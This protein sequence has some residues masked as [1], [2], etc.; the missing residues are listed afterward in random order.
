MDSKRKDKRQQAEQWKRHCQRCAE[1]RTTLVRRKAH[2]KKDALKTGLEPHPGENYREHMQM[3]HYTVHLQLSAFFYGGGLSQPISVDTAI[4]AGRKVALRKFCVENDLWDGDHSVFRAFFRELVNRIM[5][6]TELMIA[7]L[8]AGGELN[9]GPSPVKTNDYIHGKNR[10][11]YDGCPRMSYFCNK[12][13]YYC[14]YCFVIVPDARAD[15]PACLAPDATDMSASLLGL[16]AVPR[17]QIKLKPMSKKK[18]AVAERRQRRKDERRVCQPLPKPDRVV[19]SKKGTFGVTY[20][21]GAPKASE[22]VEPSPPPVDKG[23]EPLVAP[24]ASPDAPDEPLFKRGQLPM[25][26]TPGYRMVTAYGTFEDEFKQPGSS[27][28]VTIQPASA[29][30]SAPTEGAKAPAAGVGDKTPEAPQKASNNIGSASLPSAPPLPSDPAT[31]LLQRVPPTAAIVNSVAPLPVPAMDQQAGRVNGPN[32]GGD[33][34]GCCGGSSCCCSGRTGLP[35][36]P[37]VSVRLKRDS[38]KAHSGLVFN[39]FHVQ[40]CTFEVEAEECIEEP[41]F[42]LTDKGYKEVDSRLISVRGASLCPGSYVTQRVCV[43]TPVPY[44]M[45]QHI[46]TSVLLTLTTCAF[47]YFSSCDGPIS[48][49][50]RRREVAC[51]TLATF[52]SVLFASYFGYMGWRTFHRP[53]R[54]FTHLPSVT[55]SMVLNNMARC[56]DDFEANLPMLFNRYIGSMNVPSQ[57]VCTMQEGCIEAALLNY[58]MLLYKKAHPEVFQVTLRPTQGCLYRLSERLRSEGANPVDTHTVHVAAR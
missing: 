54:T 42:I 41:G 9:P 51:I 20:P 50:S 15:H 33:Q 48:D 12:G 45:W 49:C 22:E 21:A 58:D 16:D 3:R 53:Y 38:V 55:A 5:S 17:E 30:S 46:A 40:G 37:E 8:A 28:E 56:R 52:C 36:V 7:Y 13:V 57:D 4:L 47:V 39:D 32:G 26:V 34:P 29:G 25:M 24:A 44:K 18:K 31:P 6:D 35:E 19:T 27:E 2:D 43:T 10:C 11:P 14:K 1:R 23:K